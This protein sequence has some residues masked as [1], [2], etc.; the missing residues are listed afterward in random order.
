MLRSIAESADS[1]CEELLLHDPARPHKIRQVLDV[2]GALRTAQR[3][4]HNRILLPQLKPSDHSFGCVR[5]RHIKMNAGRHLRSEFAF[6]CDITNFYPSIQSSCVY[7][8]FA[9]SQ[10]CSPDV[11]RLLARLCTY[12]YHLALGLITSPLL[13]NQFLKPIDHRIAKMAESMNLVYTRYVDDITLS[14]P[15]DLRK[16]GIPGIIKRILRTNGFSTRDAK[17]QFG[18]I[19]DPDILITK[20]RINRGHLDVSCK[21]FDDL[22][23]VMRD[24]QALG[25]GGVFDRPYYTRQQIVG[26]LEFVSWINPGRRRGLMRLF[27]SVPWKKVREEA[28]TRGLVESKKT[29]QPI[30]RL[31]ARSRGDVRRR[32]RS[33][34]MVD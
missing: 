22:C 4:I 16:S 27:R 5:G 33:L 25:N 32:T 11:A 17:D 31:R 12:N 21:Y 6:S 1:Y 28:S 34:G 8:F 3:R 10:Q 14:G 19:G 9:E 15:F 2:H 24:L 18:R 23:D 26:R 20:I 30:S 29:L 13:A 7:R